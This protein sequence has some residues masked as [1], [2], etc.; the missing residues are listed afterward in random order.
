MRS[1]IGDL[2]GYEARFVSRLQH[3]FL[4]QFG[5]RCGH[6]KAIVDRQDDDALPE[7]EVHD[8]LGKVAVDVHEFCPLVRMKSPCDGPVNAL[9]VVDQ[10]GRR[11]NR[12]L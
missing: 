2:K 6:E 4:Q 10:P 5:L 12:L 9:H 11:R 1:G 7:H 8:S 3:G